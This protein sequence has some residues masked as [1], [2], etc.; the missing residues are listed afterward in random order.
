MKV[1]AGVQH[2]HLSKGK[3]AAW[4][5]PT[6]GAI[7]RGHADRASRRDALPQQERMLSCA[8]NWVCCTIQASTFASSCVYTQGM[9]CLCAAC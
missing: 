5:A 6:P 2:A 3:L 9:P 7:G 1:R 8:G 4:L